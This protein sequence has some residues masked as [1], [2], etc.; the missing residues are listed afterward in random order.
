MA[1]RAPRPIF[2]RH[3]EYVAVRPIKRSRDH[4]IQPGE[5]VDGLRQHHLRDLFRRRRIGPKGHPW[6]EAMLATDGFYRPE[7]SGGKEAEVASENNPAPEKKSE[8][9]SEGAPEGSEGGPEPAP[10]GEPNHGED[11][12]TTPEEIERFANGV[13]NSDFDDIDDF[14]D[15]W[16]N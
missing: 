16:L 14:D 13:A 10:E 9:H 7:I 6:T 11:S 8:L 4:I 12:T 2:K 3:Y 5:S 1:N 15:G